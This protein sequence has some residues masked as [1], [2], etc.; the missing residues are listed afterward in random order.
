MAGDG[1]CDSPEHC[2]ILHINFLDVESQKVVDFD[3]VS[4]SQVANSN[5]IEK[6]V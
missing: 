6:K 5:Q 4:V 2:K 3:V 1:R